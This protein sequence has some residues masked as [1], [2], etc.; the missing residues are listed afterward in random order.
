[1]EVLSYHKNKI[2]GTG[3]KICCSIFLLTLFIFIAPAS[4]TKAPRLQA[5]DCKKCHAFQWQIITKEGG[6][7]ATEIGCLDCHPQHPPKGKNTKE[8]CILCHEGQAHFQIGDCLHCHTNPHKPLVSLRD[9][10]KP[11]KS[12]C[13]SCHAA[14]GQQMAAAPSRHAKLFCNR[15]HSQHK[16]IPSCLDCHETHRPD[17]SMKDCKSCHSAHQPLQIVPSGYIPAAFCQSCHKK[18]ANDLARTKTNHGGINCIYCHKGQHPSTPACQD[19][20]GL[21]HAQLLHSQYRKCLDCHGD[22]HQLISN[23]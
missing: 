7:H 4:A 13:L 10:L 15:C 21:P 8:P 18:E 19:C 12:A 20:H 22:A 1:M 14:V 17:Q 11:E 6:E 23:Q 16:E 2:V 3:Y 9:S 5:N